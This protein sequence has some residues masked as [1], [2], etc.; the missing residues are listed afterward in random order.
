MSSII[1]VQ[2]FGHEAILWFVRNDNDVDA[3]KQCDRRFFYT[4]TFYLT[5][6]YSLVALVI[7][8]STKSFIP[9]VEYIPFGCITGT[10]FYTLWLRRCKKLEASGRITKIS[11]ELIS[12]FQT[13]WQEAGQPTIGLE[14]TAV[15]LN[16]MGYD[17]VIR[18]STAL[19][20]AD[21][22]DSEAQRAMVKKE[23]KNLL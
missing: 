5:I 10:V 16:Q 2:P 11:P 9:F 21:E 12:I 8:L 23:L 22:S 6:A 20:T 14:D 15:R 18:L 19:T 7:F 4:I 17:R 3:V 1:A 13:I